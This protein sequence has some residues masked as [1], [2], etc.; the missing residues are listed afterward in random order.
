[1][2]AAINWLTDPINCEV[3]I[4]WSYISTLPYAFVA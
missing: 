3:K 2:V 4:E 1:M